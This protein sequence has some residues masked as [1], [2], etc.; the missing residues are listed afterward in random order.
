M[1]LVE[2]RKEIESSANRSVSMPIAGAYACVWLVLALVSTRFYERSG[3]LIHLLGTGP[4]SLS[5]Y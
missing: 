5:R 3:V 1:T 4:F 2:Y